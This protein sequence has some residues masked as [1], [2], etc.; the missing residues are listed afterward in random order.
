MSD[1]WTGILQILPFNLGNCLL[2]IIAILLNRILWEIS[3]CS[4]LFKFDNVFGTN[5]VFKSCETPCAGS[6]RDHAFP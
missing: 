3:T 5:E 2:S 4:R 1:V 6:N